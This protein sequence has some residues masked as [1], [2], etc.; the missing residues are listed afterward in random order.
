MPY[1]FP[2]DVEQLV[3]AQMIAGDYRTEDDLLRDALKVLEEHRQTVI[4][5][6]PEVL[7]GVRRGLDEMKQGLG[8][9][10]EQFDT[11]FRAKHKL[12]RDA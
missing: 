6:D 3:R 9:P 11:E 4:Y 12:P 10:F 7:A 5:D 2:P 1:Q 8:R